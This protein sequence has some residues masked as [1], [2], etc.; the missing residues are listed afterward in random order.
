MASK[1]GPVIREIREAVMSAARRADDKLPDLPLR[2]KSQLATMIRRIRGRDYFDGNPTDVTSGSRPRGWGDR[3]TRPSDVLDTDK[4]TRPDPDS[5]LT[6][7]YIQQH[8]RQ[9]D[10]G[11]SRFQDLGG[12]QSYGPYRT[13]GDGK[14]FVLPSSEVDRILARADG[15][16]RVVE[17]ELGLPDGMF[18]DGPVTVVDFP[19]ATPD[20]IRIPSGNETG[21]SDLWEPGGKT[22]GGVPEGVLD[23]DSPG[24]GNH[25]ARTGDDGLP[26]V[27]G[28]A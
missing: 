7:G 28:G 2:H 17:R 25:G 15:D 6:D 8:R 3:N 5:Y 21:A 26:F 10:D 22:S 20:D 27:I 4:G 12:Y 1:L 9:F 14:G 13:D 19:D 11:A 24:G 18:G 23:G 16:L